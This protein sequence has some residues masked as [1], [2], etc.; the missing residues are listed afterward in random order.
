[1]GGKIPKIMWGGMYLLEKKNLKNGLKIFFVEK[2]NSKVWL[3]FQNDK[4]FFGPERD[5]PFKMFFGKNS[6]VTAKKVAIQNILL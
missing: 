1:M 2:K 4:I 3:R 5:C 6:C